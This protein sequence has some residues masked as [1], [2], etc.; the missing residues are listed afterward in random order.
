MLELKNLV[1][2]CKSAWVDFPGIDGFS[3]ELTNLSRKELIALR[4]R[5]TI[6]KFDKRRQM[7]EE[8]DDNRFIKEFSKAV[9]KNWKG[10]TLA[11]L[12][13]L[14]LIEVGDRDYSEELPYSQDNAE[15]L[16]SS[17]PEFDTFVNDR[18]FDIENFRN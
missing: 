15:L 5:C 8:L 11:N 7:V 13:K 3:V 17:S 18:A 16:I 2:D 9:I 1:V 4:K 6:T 14:I 10:L 12:S